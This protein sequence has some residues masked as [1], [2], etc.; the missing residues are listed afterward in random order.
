MATWQHEAY[1]FF[2]CHAGPFAY[3][4]PTPPPFSEEG[5][6]DL[7]KRGSGYLQAKTSTSFDHLCPFTP[8]VQIF[9]I[10]SSLLNWEN[11]ELGL[12]LMMDAGV[13]RAG[14]VF[15]SFH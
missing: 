14:V 7:L 12:V 3:S 8:V 15:F 9:M 10:P 13:R 4:D 5:V 1:L 11:F 6:D 2:A